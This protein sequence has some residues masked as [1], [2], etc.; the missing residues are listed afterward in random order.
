MMKDFLV[1]GLAINL[2]IKVVELFRTLQEYFNENLNI[3]FFTNGTILGLWNSIV[4]F[5]M[6]LL[7]VVVAFSL[8][9]IFMELSSVKESLIYLNKSKSD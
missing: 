7:Q 8:I 3:L 1:Y 6:P 2:L 5:F 4:Y 9:Y